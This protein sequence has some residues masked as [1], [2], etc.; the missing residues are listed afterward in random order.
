VITTQ[1]GFH[2]IKMVERIPAKKATLAEATPDIR[3]YLE[4]VAFRK[5]LPEYFAELKKNADVE[6]L[7]PKLKEAEMPPAGQSGAVDSVPNVTRPAATTH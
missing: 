7:D 4:T 6:I 1:F 2:L 5:M 3:R